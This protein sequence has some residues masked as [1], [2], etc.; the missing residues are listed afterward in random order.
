MKDGKTQICEI[1]GF[2]LV[3]LIA[4]IGMMTIMFAIALPALHDWISNFSYRQTARQITSMCREARNLAISKNLQHMV[5]VNPGSNDC[6]IF[7]GIRAYNTLLP[8][9]PS[10]TLPDA[11]GYATQVDK[12][13][14]AKNS[15]IRSGAAG[16]SGN[17]TYV[18]FN[19]NGTAILC[20]QDG[21][22]NDGS[23]SVNDGTTQKY[24]ISVTQTG[25]ISL[26]KM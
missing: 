4:V 11:S 8:L 2:T 21:T 12:L 7:R 1:K 18:Q 23:I 9:A 26:Q 25:R 15:V 24:R 6:R 20:D 3:E 22:D 17:T 19:P 5:V 16:T 13:I 14:A 10:Y